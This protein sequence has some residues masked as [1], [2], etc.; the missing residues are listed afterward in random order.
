MTGVEAGAAFRFSFR[1]AASAT[2]AEAEEAEGGVV[3]VL[4]VDSAAVADLVDSEAVAASEV[5]EGGRAGEPNQERAF[6]FPF[7]R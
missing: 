7:F 2:S 4:E 3:E 1:P 5:V 6:R